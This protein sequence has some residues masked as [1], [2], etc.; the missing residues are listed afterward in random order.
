MRTRFWLRQYLRR[1]RRG[2]TGERAAAI[3]RL[4][5]ARHQ[6]RRRMGVDLDGAGSTPT[7]GSDPHVS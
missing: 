7:S 4:R 2:G 6:T 3:Q 5:F 1:L